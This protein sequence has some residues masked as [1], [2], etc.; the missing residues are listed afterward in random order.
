MT[1]TH[2]TPDQI[3]DPLPV[4]VADQTGLTIAH[5][6]K[7]PEI[8]SGI[9]TEVLRQLYSTD[10]GLHLNRQWIWSE[11]PSDA[12]SQV[13][14]NAESVWN[15][16][17]PDF[18]PAIYV[19]LTPLE[20]KST[21]GRPTGR[22]GMNLP[23]G[24]YQYSRMGSGQVRF[25]HIGRTQGETLSLLSNTLDLLDAFSDI[26]RQDFCFRTLSVVQV[27]PSK[28]QD[29]ETRER[30]RGEVIM[31]FQFEDTWVL[32]LESPKLKRVVFDAGL[33]LEE[34]L[35]FQSTLM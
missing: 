13:W 6:R 10:N 2:I 22:T 35:G 30:F 12:A 14:I 3:T 34:V 20:Y 8:L 21:T 32:K 24:E 25:V 26:I 29:R 17:A 33:R 1:V 5:V 27:V 31:A 19:A 15:D 23:E 18:R 16:A 9:F 11:K 4:L 28:P 7:T